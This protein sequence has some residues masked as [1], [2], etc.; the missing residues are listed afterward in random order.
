[1]SSITQIIHPLY[2]V[3]GGLLAAIYSIFPNYAVAIGLLTIVVITPFTPLTAKTLK[4]SA[5]MQKIQPEIKK[6]NEL[7]KNDPT[8]KQEETMALFKRENVNP[9]GGCLPMLPQ[10][11]ILFVFYNVIKGLTNFS[12]VKGKLQP[13]PLYIPKNSHLFQTIYANHGNMISFGMNLSDKITAHHGSFGQSIPYYL[14]LVVGTILQY[15][16]V[17][18]MSSRMPQNNQIN[19]QAQFFMQKV[20]PLG[21]MFFYLILPVGVCVYY[22]VSTVV[23]IFQYE[24]VYFRHPGLASGDYDGV[25]RKIFNFTLPP[26]NNFNSNNKNSGSS[27]S[28]VIDVKSTDE[29]SSKN[30]SSGNKNSGSKSNISEPVEERK[31]QH[32]RSKSKKRRK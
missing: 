16:Q 14:I 8:K 20:M 31:K 29:A 9:A 6:I 24:Y 11:V 19:A 4:T 3:F 27:N 13:N 26:V 17:H 18:R 15:I 23:R 22:L 12:K 5:K 10:F 30:K 7:Y 21:L 25:K 1:M 32:P 28:D 2:V